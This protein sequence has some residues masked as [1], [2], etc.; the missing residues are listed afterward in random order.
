MRITTIKTIAATS[1]K[2]VT[3]CSCSTLLSA[4]GTCKSR[5]RISHRNKKK[6][7]PQLG[8]YECNGANS[9]FASERT[10]S[11]SIACRSKNTQRLFYLWSNAE[12]CG[13]KQK[14]TVYLSVRT[15]DAFVV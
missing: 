9:N 15:R 13:C 1:K 4:A 3:I 7:T 12:K 8:G 6:T 10:S 5:S 2:P 14:D 11:K